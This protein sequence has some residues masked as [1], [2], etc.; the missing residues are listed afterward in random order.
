MAQSE[1]KL[2]NASYA[3]TKRVKKILSNSELLV[4]TC[5]HVFA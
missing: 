3:K 4:F 1:A 2:R 5:L